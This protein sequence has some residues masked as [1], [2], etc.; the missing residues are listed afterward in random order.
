MYTT[1]EIKELLLT[2]YEKGD[3]RIL[4]GGN[5]KQQTKTVELQNIQFVANKDHIIRKPNYDYAQREIQ[6]YHTMSLNVNDIPGGAPTMWSACATEEGIINSNYGWMIYSDENY[7]Q[8][9]SCL[10]KLIKDPHTREACM[11][12]QRPSMQVDYCRDGMHDFCCTWSVQCFI[13]E[14]EGKRHLKY[15]YNMRSQDAVFGFNNDILW[16]MHVQEAL[17]KDLSEHFGE[18]VIADPIE[19]NVGSLHVY[20]RHFRFLTE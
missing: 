16:H 11:I 17:V 2:K 15:I 7:N 9:Q 18:E 8:Y 10:N 1:E 20:E 14:V 4:G 19:C 6:W 12:Y 3:F 13:N 5:D